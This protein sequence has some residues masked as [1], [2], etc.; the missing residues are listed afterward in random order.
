MFGT[1]TIVILCCVFLVTTAKPL[2]RRNKTMGM[3]RIVDGNEVDISN[4]PFQVAV[5]PS[6]A[7]CGGSLIRYNIVLTAAHCV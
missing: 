1:F 4:R 3:G 6:D 5:L 2:V 7:L